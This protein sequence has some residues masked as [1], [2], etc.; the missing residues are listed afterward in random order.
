MRANTQSGAMRNSLRQNSK[1]PVKF[2]GVIL[3]NMLLAE[4]QNDEPIR[5]S[6]RRSDNKLHIDGKILPYEKL[7][8]CAPKKTEC[9]E[10]HWQKMLLLMADRTP[11]MKI[12][13]FL[14]VAS[15]CLK[16]R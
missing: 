10:R 7:S 9:A 1:R 11:K 8:V 2:V 12:L 3:G 13:L 5:Y 4:M 15:P 6:G 14:I 16:Q